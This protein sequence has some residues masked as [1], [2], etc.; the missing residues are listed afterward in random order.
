MRHEFQRGWHAIRVQN[1]NS[2][3][4][5]RM[6]SKKMPAQRQANGR[7]H[8][9]PNSLAFISGFL[10]SGGES[11]IVHLSNPADARS[12]ADIHPDRYTHRAGST[13]IEE[14]TVLNLFVAAVCGVAI[15][16]AF[17]SADSPGRADVEA[18]AAR[19]R[20]ERQQ[21]ESTGVAA[22]FPAAWMQRA[23]DLAARAE[24]ARS[25]GLNGEALTLYRDARWQLPARLR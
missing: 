3:P 1:R 12:L 18:V 11:R 2:S 6:R 15:A 21:A 22:R 4:I 24:T 8:D 16:A 20:A 10:S 7:H 14:V 9:N 17:L 23:D 13:R 19:Y 5:A 25:A